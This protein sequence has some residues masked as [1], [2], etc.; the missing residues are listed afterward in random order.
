MTNT[1]PTSWAELE[2]RFTEL[3][4]KAHR[5]LTDLEKAEFHKLQET[6]TDYIDEQN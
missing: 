5:G 1:K 2:A 4:E 6:I 3:A